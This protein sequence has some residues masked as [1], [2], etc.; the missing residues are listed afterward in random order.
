MNLGPYFVTLEYVA[1]SGI[2][3]AL[4]L[5]FLY[6]YYGKDEEEEITD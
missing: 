1:M 6:M 5:I 3:I 2:F 4:V